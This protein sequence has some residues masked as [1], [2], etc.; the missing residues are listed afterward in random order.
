MNDH[1]SRRATTIFT[2]EFV[3]Y[4][5]VL[6]RLK[7][8]FFKRDNGVVAVEISWPK[9]TCREEKFL[10]DLQI[11]ALLFVLGIY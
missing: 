5:Q 4:T 10:I 6:K 1:S 9:N 3:C 7:S 11:I 8:S 2:E